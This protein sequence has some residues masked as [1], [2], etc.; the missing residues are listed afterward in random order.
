MGRMD[1]PFIPGT[2]RTQVLDT[3]TG[4][5]KTIWEGY[6]EMNKGQLPLNKDNFRKG[7]D[8]FFEYLFKEGRDNWPRIRSIREID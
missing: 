6:L 3:K 4:L 7:A 5:G 1:Y 8:T 2:E